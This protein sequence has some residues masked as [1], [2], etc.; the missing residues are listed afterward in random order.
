[1]QAGRDHRFARFRFDRR[2]G[3]SR[4]GKVSCVIDMY[5]WLSQWKEVD[6]DEVAWRTDR[7]HR[8]LLP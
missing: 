5:L 7:V 1:M 8:L 6:V 3:R 4:G 2:L